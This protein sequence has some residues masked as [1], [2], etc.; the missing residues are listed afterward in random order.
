MKKQLKNRL[1]LPRTLLSLLQLRTFLLLL[2]TFSLAACSGSGSNEAAPPNTNTPG[3]VDDGQLPKTESPTAK[4]EVVPASGRIP[5]LADIKS[6]KGKYRPNPNSVG[7]ITVQVNDFCSV[8]IQ[9]EKPISNIIFNLGEDDEENVEYIYATVD[10]VT[11]ASPLGNTYTLGNYADLVNVEGD[12]VHIKAGNNG[13][14]GVG[15]EIDIDVPI[16]EACETPMYSDANIGTQREGGGWIIKVNE[17]GL[18]GLEA[19]L[20]DVLNPTGTFGF[21]WGCVGVDVTDVENLFNLA[22]KDDNSGAANTEAI[23]NE[24]CVTVSLGGTTAAQAA[25]DYEWPDGSADGFLPNR[26][27]LNLMYNTIGYGNSGGYDDSG[28]IVGG[29]TNDDPYWSSSEY[30]GSNAWFQGMISGFQNA[31]TKNF[32]FRVRAVRAF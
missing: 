16:T 15:E 26:E 30:V 11:T 18:G 25:S 32:K 5:L 10:G 31:S 7:E 28:D 29:F 17:D 27:Q 21:E 6:K 13:K 23:I 4:F 19:A 2:V 24:P 1:V 12:V 20:A 8:Y 9:S 22:S 3:I 14:R